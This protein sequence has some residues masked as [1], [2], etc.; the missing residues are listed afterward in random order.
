MHAPEIHV[1]IFLKVLG[2][3][4]I[5]WKIKILFWVREKLGKLSNLEIKWSGRPLHRQYRC[6]Q[7]SDFF[8]ILQDFKVLK[9]MEQGQDHRGRPFACRQIANIFLAIYKRSSCTRTIFTW[10]SSPRILYGS[11]VA[12]ADSTHSLAQECFARTHTIGATHFLHI[13]FFYYYANCEHIFNAWINR[14]TGR[15]HFL[16]L[17]LYVYSH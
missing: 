9:S 16:L 11:A 10:M 14:R 2:F 3:F 17:S 7:F 4:W 12:F 5:S 8:L 13:F 15:I 6:S 1:R